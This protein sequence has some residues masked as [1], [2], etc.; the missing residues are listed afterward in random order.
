MLASAAVL[1][2]VTSACGGTATTAATTSGNVRVSGGTASYALPPAT[3][4]DYIFPFASGPY[5]SVANAQ[6]FQYLMYRPLYWFGNGASPTL[7]TS[8]SLAGAPVYDGRQVTITM[9]G[10]KWSDGETVGAKDVLFWI[11]MM[12]AVGSAD[13]G[14]YVPGGFPSNVSDVTATGDSTLTMTM[15]KSFNHTWFTSNELSQITPMPRAWDRTA[16]GASDCT[17]DVSDCPAVYRYLDSQSR[18]TSTWT[19][20]PL[21]SVVDGPWRLRSFTAG[22][23]ST[24]VPNTDYDGPVKATLARFQ[25]MPFSTESAEYNVL[26]ASGSG[27]QKLD[28][29][30]L[31]VSDAPAK[32]AG[33]A[34]GSN[35]V[36]GYTLSPLYLWGINYFPL[37]LQS[38]TGNGPVFAQLYVRQALQHLMDARAVIGGPL[39]GYGQDT[40]GPVPAYPASSYLS[41]ADDSLTYSPVTARELLTSHGWKVVA[42]GATTCLTPSLCGSGI[43]KGHPLAF[44]ISYATGTGWIEPELTQLRSDAARLGIE[45]TLIPRPFGQVT[46]QAGNCAVIRTSCDWDA[47]DW[48]GGWT[49]MPDYYPTGE[50]LFQ[51]GSGANSG[52]Y[53]DS[54]NDA[55]ISATLTTNSV[56]PLYD[57]QDYLSRQVPVIWQPS[58][59]YQ[60][61]EITDSLR[62]VTPQSSTAN[63]NPENWHFTR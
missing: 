15:T 5:L 13:W 14:A 44:T 51:S 22:G 47:S 60:L 9:K 28:V 16:S 19:T 1:T 61:T 36:S 24:F 57:W 56:T 10:W 55:L 26:R 21:W 49:F 59:A 31:P 7:N 32:P 11:H 48:G 39:K 2:L 34:V 46:A 53:T 17:D 4:P 58:G 54:R 41:S 43:A 12:R 40:V 20:S 27:G 33:A 38:T 3:A 63:L 6:Y 23:L 62:G 29:G 50:T 45:I 30:Y 18:S 42:G 52:G 8:L 35:P 37:N 25:E